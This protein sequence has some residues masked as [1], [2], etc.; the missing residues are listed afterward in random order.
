M[1]SG[2]KTQTCVHPI[3]RRDASQVIDE[4]YRVET[5]YLGCAQYFSRECPD[6]INSESTAVGRGFNRILVAFDSHSN[7]IGQHQF[8]LAGFHRV[9][10]R[11]VFL[12][13]HII[14]TH[15]K[16][17]K[18]LTDCDLALYLQRPSLERLGDH[19]NKS[20]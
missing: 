3:Y 16:Y 5:V 1:E 12:L 19:G 8:G 2:A 11:Y 9:P 20:L 7:R 10:L 4:S 13:V 17:T 6:A 15:K 18:K 14:Q